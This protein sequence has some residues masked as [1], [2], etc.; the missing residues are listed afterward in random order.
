MSIYYLLSSIEDAS[1]SQTVNMA[2]AEALQA[3]ADLGLDRRD[4]VSAPGADG[5]GREPRMSTRQERAILA[6]DQDRRARIATAGDGGDQNA[7]RLSAW[8]STLNLFSKST[9]QNL[10]L[11]QTQPRSTRTTWWRI[12]RTGSMDKDIVQH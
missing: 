5:R 9:R 11:H 10:T 3:M 12:S 7:A 8:N 2:S 4:V 1:G 6:E